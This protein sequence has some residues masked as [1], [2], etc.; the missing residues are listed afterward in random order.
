[1]LIM[2]ASSECPICGVDTPHEHDALTVL[3]Y[4]NYEARL[5]R[6]KVEEHQKK[7][8]RRQKVDGWFKEHLQKQVDDAIKVRDAYDKK[9]PC[10]RIANRELSTA[11]T[12]SL[13][14]YDYGWTVKDEEVY[15]PEC[16][17]CLWSGQS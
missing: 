11:V 14:V 10:C 3:E 6:E 8:I 16:G 5:N 2:E 15:C 17:R 4:R 1:M 12:G 9:C 13:C 7:V